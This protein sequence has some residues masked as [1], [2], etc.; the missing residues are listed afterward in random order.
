VL[1]LLQSLL[2]AV[3]ECRSRRPTWVLAY[4]DPGSGALLVQVLL[5]VAVGF[6]LYLKRVR[7]A[8]KRIVLWLCRRDG[9]SSSG[10][11]RLD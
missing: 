5:S 1:L 2:G 6:M 10:N 7:Q 4:I 11:G 8:L 9:G 3:I